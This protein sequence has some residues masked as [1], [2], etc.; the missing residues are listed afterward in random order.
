LRPD[1][2]KASKQT[3]GCRH[4]TGETAAAPDHELLIGTAHLFM[5]T[6]M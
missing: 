1:G 4:V 6:N 3:R 5:I 2:A